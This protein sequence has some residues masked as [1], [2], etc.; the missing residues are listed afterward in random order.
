MCSMLDC[1]AGYDVTITTVCNAVSIVNGISIR[2]DGLRLQTTTG[3]PD[4]CKLLSTWLNI[5]NRFKKVV[6]AWGWLERD[7]MSY[8]L[9]ARQNVPVYDCV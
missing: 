8:G 2:N 6:E 5:T 1:F 4:R 7:T 3:P 9:Y